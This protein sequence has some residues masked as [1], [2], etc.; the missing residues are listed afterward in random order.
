MEIFNET[1]C[2]GYSQEE[3]DALN[4]EFK[5]RYESGEYEGWTEDEAAKYFC[6]EVARR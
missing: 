2:E 3:M 5:E 4:S 6:D 1:N